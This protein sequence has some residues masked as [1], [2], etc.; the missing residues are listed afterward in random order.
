MANV[1]RLFIGDHPLHGMGAYCSMQNVNVLTADKFQMAWSTLFES[2]QI[3]SS[4]FV[5]LP[6]WD[7]SAEWVWSAPFAWQN[8]GYQPLI[9]LSMPNHRVRLE[10]LSTSS[11]RVIIDPDFPTTDTDGGNCHFAVTKTRRPA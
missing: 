6:D 8:L 2:L 5:T 9:L 10:Y 1:N 11:A 3:L 7:N 4:G